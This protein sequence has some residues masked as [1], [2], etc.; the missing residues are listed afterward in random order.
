M[1]MAGHVEK[2]HLKLPEVDK[3]LLDGCV[4]WKWEDVRSITLSISRELRESVLLPLAMPSVC[5][6]CLFSV[7]KPQNLAYPPIFSSYIGSMIQRLSFMP[8]GYVACSRA[9]WLYQAS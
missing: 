9:L 6:E 7:L 3:L 4:L 8:L 2:R 5:T 1:G